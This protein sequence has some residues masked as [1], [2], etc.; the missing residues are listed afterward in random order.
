[1]GR[2]HDPWSRIPGAVRMSPS[3]SRLHCFEVARL[4]TANR[5]STVPIEGEAWD[6]GGA[7]RRP[8]ATVAARARRMAPAR[9]SRRCVRAGAHLIGASPYVTGDWIEIFE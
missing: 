1:M 9:T 8:I 4:R 6:G 3:G 7:S 5:P 2:Q